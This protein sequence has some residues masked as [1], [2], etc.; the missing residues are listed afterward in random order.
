MMNHLDSPEK[1]REMEELNSEFLSV[2]NSGE[3]L[4]ICDAFLKVRF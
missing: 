2:F 4:G 1:I 3:V